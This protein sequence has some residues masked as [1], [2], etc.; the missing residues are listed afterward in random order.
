MKNEYTKIVMKILFTVLLVHLS[1]FKVRAQD[2]T[3]KNSTVNH[4]GGERPCLVVNIDPEP[5]PLKK[6]WKSFLKDNY[7][8]KIK[9]IGF[10]TNKDL[11]SR[12][13]VVIEE[14]SSKRLDFYTKIVEDEIGSEMK[15]F[16]SFGYDIY[17]N[18]EEMKE[19]YEV[20]KKMLN[21]F[22]KSYLPKYYKSEVKASKKKVKKLSKEVKGLKKD[23]AKNKDEI[24]DLKKEVEELS[25]EV[26][27]KSAQLE[28]AETKLNQRKL[29]LERISSY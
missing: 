16:A 20:M 10:L 1:F 24:E 12:K 11:L 7:D 8:F 9:G 6:E 19:E 5:K 23:I 22:L 4:N 26:T 27:E 18:K 21:D 29:K 25:E 2:I 14:I 17:I 28:E 3:I 15:V 13:D